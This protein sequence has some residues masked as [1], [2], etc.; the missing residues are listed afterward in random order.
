NWGAGVRVQVLGKDLVGAQIGI[1]DTKV[2]FVDTLNKFSFKLILSN[3]TEIL[4]PIIYNSDQF[5]TDWLLLI[6]KNTIYFYANGR[7]IFNEAYSE[8]G[9]KSFQVMLSSGEENIIFK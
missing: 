2:V 9:Q 5:P 7:I 8:V 1:G 6:T 4:S 3:Q